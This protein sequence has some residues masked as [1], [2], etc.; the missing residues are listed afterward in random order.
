MPEQRVV[1]RARA[2]DLVSASR[3]VFSAETAAAIHGLGLY[4]PDRTRVHVISPT[5][6][7]GAAQGVVRHRGDLPDD[8][9]VEVTGLLLTSLE[10][11]VADTARTATFEQAVTIAD[12]ALRSEATP[13]PGSYDLA[14]AAAFLETVLGIARRSAH[15]RS[16]SD[17]VLRFADGRAQ[18]PGESISR[19]R[20]SEIGF[21]AVTLQVAVDAP[22][23][24]TYYVDF[25]LD[26]VHAL[27]EFDGAMK[28]V[29]GRLRDGRTASEILDREKQREDWIRGRTQRRLA[30]WG[31]PH[32][33]T[34]KTL[35]SRL[36]DFGIH[37]P[38]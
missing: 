5:A 38:T 4:R 24:G 25:G 3:P 11:T 26:D 31:W 23:G 22:N 29:D 15:G 37:P 32:V 36:A 16:R 20:L 28:Y 19:I 33:E 30:R 17:R 6:R 34:A 12:A 27:G 1:A 14:R 2:L 9:V 13:G 7:P 10:R 21:R 35:G 8:Q 18:L